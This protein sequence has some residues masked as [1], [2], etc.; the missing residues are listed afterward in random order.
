M[1]LKLA[2]K[3][4]DKDNVATIFADGIVDGT[5]VEIRDKR[6]DSEK[7]SV[8]GDVPFGHKIAVRDIHKDMVCAA[9]AVN[10]QFIMNVALDGEKKVVAAW[11][12]DL[13]EA[14]AAGVQFIREQSQC[15]SIEGD[16]V[17]TSNGGYPLDQNLYQ[18]PKAVATAEACCRDGGV[19][20]SK[21]P[22]MTI[23]IPIATR[24]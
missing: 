10:V 17:V 5:E 7:V 2:L 19:I 22:M 24:M 8:I 20:I 11:A 12:G 13:E 3:V 6:G 15:P 4:S 23:A 1:D 16:I 14:H 18:S 9:R 21:K